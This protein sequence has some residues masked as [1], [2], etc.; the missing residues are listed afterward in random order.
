MAM[1]ITFCLFPA[2]SL[3][4]LLVTEHFGGEASDLGWLQATW[5]A[6]LVI[7]GVLLSVWGGFERKIITF[8]AGLTGLGMGLLLVGLMPGDTF[9]PTLAAM[10]LAGIMYPIHAGP[11]TA[12]IQA[13]VDPAMQG[14][15]MALLGSVTNAIA[16][17]S[18]ALAGPLAESFGPSAW[19]ILAGSLCILMGLGGFTL[20]VLLG[21][22]EQGRALAAAGD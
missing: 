7:G 16:P 18:L 21:M 15:V 20:P 13:S 4:P 2:F 9:I 22:E 6:G 5:G 19:F 11:Y 10:G 1:L 8:L 14:R 3:I 12:T 17:I